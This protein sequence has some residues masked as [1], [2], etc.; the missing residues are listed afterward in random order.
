MKSAGRHHVN[1]R[2][3]HGYL[4]MAQVGHVQSAMTVFSVG[5][6]LSLAPAG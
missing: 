3:G 5:M 4:F 6:E 2:V 1:R